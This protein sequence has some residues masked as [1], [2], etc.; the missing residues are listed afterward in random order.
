MP[1]RRSSL[2]ALLAA[3]G[4][5]RSAAADGPT[6]GRTTTRSIASTRTGASYPLNIYRP[7]DAPGM[8]ARLPVVYLLDGESR[9]Q[10]L[11][12]IAAA[13]GTRTMIVGIGNEDRR[14]HD[15]VPANTCTE[16]GGGEAAFFDFIRFELIPFVDAELGGDPAKRVLMGH[17]H[18]GAF[19]LY[20]LF[21]EAP[22]AH[23]FGA[24]L[25]ADAS[26]RCMPEAVY[27][28]EA[29][30]AARA[31][32]LPAR[33]YLAYA[34]PSNEPFARQIERRHYRGLRFASQWYPGGHNGMVQAG[35]TDALRFAFAPD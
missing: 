19:V 7:P 20:A 29:A 10:T 8:P 3:L 11:A 18:G 5:A 33:L 12:D 26:V 16:D 2:I 35:F 24:Y 23:H 1:T 6:P 22:D 21:N 28:W 17:S 31:E 13:S 27:G 15:Y 34:N 9:F 4:A 14:S 32:R 25:A 30:Y